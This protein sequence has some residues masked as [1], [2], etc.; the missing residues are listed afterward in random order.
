M[1]FFDLINIT[2]FFDLKFVYFNQG[3]Q[4]WEKMKNTPFNRFNIDIGP[5]YVSVFLTILKYVSV[6][7]SVFFGR[8]IQSSTYF[9]SLNEEQMGLV[10]TQTNHV[11]ICLF[12][13]LK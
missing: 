2:F 11:C 1:T 12:F 10:R 8:P 5:I 7:V 3:E 6:S 4:V 13:L 9:F